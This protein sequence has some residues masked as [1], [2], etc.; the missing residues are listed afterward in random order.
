MNEYLIR[1]AAGHEWPAV[2]RE[3]AHQVLSP[4]GFECAAVDGWGDVR[5]RCGATEVAFSG[6]DIGW[7]ASFEGPMADDETDRFVAVVTRQVEQAV[8]EPCEWLRIT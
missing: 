2:H 5:L 6:E 4:V 1:T 7:Q 3:Q 8:G